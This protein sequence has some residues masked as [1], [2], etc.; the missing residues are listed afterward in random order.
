MKLSENNAIFS[1]KGTNYYRAPE[2]RGHME[3]VLS[4]QG[5]KGNGE[6]SEQDVNTCGFALDSPA[7]CVKFELPLASDTGKLGHFEPF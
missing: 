7:K 2:T 1:H 3:I 6:M 5:Q 4:R